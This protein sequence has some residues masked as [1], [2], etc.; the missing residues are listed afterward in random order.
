MC[1]SASASF[2][3]SA[4]L[5]LIGMVTLKKSNK[6][7]QLPFA[8][9]PLIFA[10]QQ[11]SEGFVWLALTNL[12]Y[13]FWLKPSAHIFLFFAQVIWPSWVPWSILSLEKDNRRKDALR[14]AC[15]LGFLTSVYLVYRLFTQP[16]DASIMGMHISYNIG[17]I[18]STLQYSALLYFIV[19]V[20][21]PFISSV[22]KM[23]LFGLSIAISYMVTHLFFQDYELSVW[24]FFAAIISIAVFIILFDLQKSFLEKIVDKEL[25]SELRI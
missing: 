21:P 11:A 13:L 10:V 7:E 5:S 17:S 24:C 20:V 4:V 15:G 18:N 14:L 6:P 25:P 16:I 22:P 19:T 1:F 12:T 9:I 23:S 8:A 2:G 3:A